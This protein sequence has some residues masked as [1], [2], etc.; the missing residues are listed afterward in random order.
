MTN[1]SAKIWIGG[2]PM[3]SGNPIEDLKLQSDHETAI[4]IL[5]KMLKI[6]DIKYSSAFSVTRSGAM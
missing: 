4:Q 6:D 3:T 1:V 5:P 2:N